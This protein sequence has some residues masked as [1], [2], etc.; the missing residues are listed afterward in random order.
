MNRNRFA[1][2]LSWAAVL[3]SGLLCLNSC[4][5]DNDDGGS[6]DGSST[7]PVV[8]T[9]PG[10]GDAMSPAGHIWKPLPESLWI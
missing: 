5:D 4:G 2:K 7:D 3:L 8:P 6:G 9:E 10:Q 1:S